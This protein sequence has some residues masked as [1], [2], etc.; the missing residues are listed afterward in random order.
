MPTELFTAGSK[1]GGTIL[2]DPERERQVYDNAFGSRVSRERSLAEARLAQARHLAN[3]ARTVDMVRKGLGVSEERA[4]L[5]HNIL[6]SMD[7]GDLRPLGATLGDLQA[8]DFR[9]MAVDALTP[10]MGAGNA[11]LA[12]LDGKPLKWTAVDGGHVVRPYAPLGSPTPTDL[13]TA[14]IEQLD[15][16]RDRARRPPAAVQQ[17][18]WQVDAIQDEIGRNLTGQELA[19]LKANKL[20]LR[21]GADGKTL[22]PLGREVV[23]LP[24][25]GRT[26]VAAAS[27]LPPLGSGANDSP[28]NTRSA[29]RAERTKE[30]G[31]QALA[32]ARRA[33][34]TGRISKDKAR[35]RLVDAGFVNV[36]GRL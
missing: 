10:E 12:A 18:E 3:S 15:A 29:Y 28:G 26:T 23:A 34:A 36:A 22:P 24:P 7:E 1:I 35:Q 2:G 27:E 25:L 32:D 13:T 17:M 19:D 20:N 21:I 16:Q 5:F 11:A 31:L 9:Q 8:R 33:I 6:G 14:R 4:V 30:D